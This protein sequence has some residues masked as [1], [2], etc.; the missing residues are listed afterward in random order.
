MPRPRPFSPTD[1]AQ[2]A[3]RFPQRLA[4]AAL[5]A[6]LALLALLALAA[7][8]G[9]APQV[10][11]VT[12][13]CVLGDNDSKSDARRICLLEAKRKAVEQAGTIIESRTEV[14]D[15]RVAADQVKSY[16]AASVRVL[17]VKER[18]TASGDTVTLTL[19]LRAEVD[20]EAAA[21]GLAQA[22]REP[23]ALE[24]LER[25]AGD[26]RRLEDAALDLQRRIAGADPGAALDFRREQ[27]RVFTS[28]DEAYAERDR[29]LAGMRET[30]KLAR[31]TVRKGMTVGEVGRLL[32]Q[33]RALKENRNMPSAYTCANYGAAWVVFKD[34]LVECVRD[35]LV[36]RDRYK[37]DCH[38]GGVNLGDVFGE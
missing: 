21:K 9:A 31:D 26:A 12:Q 23:A 18:F 25:G 35:S 29:I 16:A 22:V 37:S 7:P 20:P 27:R 8:A 33:P 32:G 6:L 28:L 24:R 34:G 4:G 15:S 36:Y 38:C 30:G 14:R 1:P 17:E 3:A 19:D 13:S 2:G 11:S 5:A 10:I